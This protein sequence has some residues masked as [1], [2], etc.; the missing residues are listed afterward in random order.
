M[1]V[2]TFFENFKEKMKDFDSLKPEINR[3]V[4]IYIT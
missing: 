1:D 4:L 3:N 2:E